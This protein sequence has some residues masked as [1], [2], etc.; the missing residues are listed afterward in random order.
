MAR[1]REQRR[2]SG[3]VR[4]HGGGIWLVRGLGAYVLLQFGWWAYLL[5]VSGG[6]S[7]KWMVLGEGSVFATLLILGLVRLERSVRKE[8]ERIAR[9][10]NLLLGVTH[11]LKTP[12][13]SVQ[14]GLDSLRR[15]NL[16]KE[17]KSQVLSNMQEGIHDLGNLV[18]D[19]LVAT[20]VQRKESM[21]LDTFSWSQ[22]VQE[23]LSRIGDAQRQRIDVFQGEEASMEVTGDKALWGLAAS[24]LVENALKYSEGKVEVHVFG[25]AQEASLE[26]RD[27]GQGIP[28]EQHAL[29]LEPFM[30]LDKESQGTGLG[31]HLVAQTAE[32]HGA[33]L[34]MEAL[35][36]SGFMVRVVWPQRR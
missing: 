1:E 5:S 27:E 31:L 18:D 30:R 15:L 3:S 6:E 11:E 8:R 36:P 13:A 4:Q 35:D 9:E 19:M 20:R 10:R 12:L 26:V 22:M 21:Q 14:L 7:A 24:N 34:D 33:S 16:E 29:V 28:M 17:D 25:T 32:L 23:A 2:V